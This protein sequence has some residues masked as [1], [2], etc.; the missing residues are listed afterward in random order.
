MTAR[1][2]VHRLNTFK[3]LEEIYSKKFNY[4]LDPQIILH[5][6]I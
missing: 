2:S 5:G 1:T 4:Q 6:L 3:T